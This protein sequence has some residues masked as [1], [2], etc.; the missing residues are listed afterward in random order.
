MNSFLCRAC[1]RHSFVRK[2]LCAEDRMYFICEHCDAQH[3]V[4]VFQTPR[5]QPTRF[6]VVGLR[7]RESTA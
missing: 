5:D 4:H 6:D 7:A 3:E 2:V 1:S